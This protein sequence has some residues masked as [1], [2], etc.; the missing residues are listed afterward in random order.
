[1]LCRLLVINYMIK[2]FQSPIL[3]FTIPHSAMKFKSGVKISFLDSASIL[4]DK[5]SDAAHA[6][7]KM[8]AKLHTTS[9]SC[10]LVSEETLREERKAH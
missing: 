7:T 8:G 5:I 9:E 1:M 10:T 4:Q 3:Y 2:K 6:L